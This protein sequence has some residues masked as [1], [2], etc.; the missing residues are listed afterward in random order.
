MIGFFMALALAVTGLG[1]DGNKRPCIGIGKYHSIPKFFCTTIRLGE[2]GKLGFPNL[3]KNITIP[4]ATKGKK[5]TILVRSI[6]INQSDIVGIFRKYP[7]NSFASGSYDGPSGFLLC[8]WN[9]GSLFGFY[10]YNFYS[11]F[12]F[13]PLCWR[14][15]SVARPDIYKWIAAPKAKPNNF[16]VNVSPQLLIGGLFCNG[17]CSPSKEQSPKYEQCSGSAQKYCQQSNRY[18]VFG[19]IRGPYLGVQLA[20]IM[21]LGIAFFALASLSL[22]RRFDENDRRYRWIVGAILGIV[23]GLTF[24]GWGF[25]GHPLRFWGLA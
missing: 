1:F 2:G 17:I 21:G 11:N 9:N 8:H 16:G 23:G 22:F 5:F 19:G 10:R 7:G 4:N 12:N 13:K 6:E 15:S 3:V 25:L 20:I 14:L 18:L 24:Y